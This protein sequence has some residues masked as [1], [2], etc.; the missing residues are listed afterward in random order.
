RALRAACFAPFHSAP[1][2]LFSFPSRYF[3][4]I[5]LPV[6]SAFDG[7]L[8]PSACPPTHAY[9]S[10]C[11]RRVRAFH[12]LCAA[13]PACSA[14]RSAAHPRRFAAGSFP[15]ARRYSGNPC[16]FLF[17]RVLICLSSAGLLTRVVRSATAA[18]APARSFAFSA[19]FLAR[20]AEGSPRGALL[21]LPRCFR[22]VCLRMEM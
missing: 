12:P 7:P 3:F 11:A 18:P 14:A 19:S 17:L 21:P 20:I 4:S 15:F 6:Y 8:H 9:S 16:S 13:V 10:R 5:G 1:A 22:I 2:R